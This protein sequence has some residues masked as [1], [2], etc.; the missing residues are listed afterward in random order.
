M[1]TTVERPECPQGHQGRVHLDGFYGRAAHFRRPRYKCIPDSGKP[2]R[3]TEPLP[4]RQPTDDHPH[5][6]DCTECGHGASRNGGPQTGRG[7]LFTAREVAGVL[8]DLGEG[9]SLRKA[10]QKARREAVR[11]RA[12][13]TGNRRASRH[14]QL[15]MNYLAAFGGRVADELLPSLWPVAVVLDANPFLLRTTY[16]DGAP[17]QGGPIGFNLMGAYGYSG[18]RG[19]G[20]L[21]RL[22]VR[23]ANDQVE[24]EVFLRSLP[25]TP[26]WVVSDGSAPVRNAVAAV[27]PDATFY[28][29]EGHL[30]R[31]GEE[32]LYKDGVFPGHPL[33]TLW[34]E[35]QW[36]FERW[37]R[38]L[39]ELHFSEASEMKSWIA[40]RGALIETQF[41]IRRSDRPRATG[42]LEDSLRNVKGAIGDR[43]FVFR[44]L[45]RLRLLLNLMALHEREDDDVRTYAQ[46]I[47][48]ALLTDGRPQFRALDDAGAASIRA[49]ALAA[50]ERLAEKREFARTASRKYEAKESK[51]RKE[52]KAKRIADEGRLQPAE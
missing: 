6:A 26:D 10:S 50:D 39:Y 18:A 44:N 30:L 5:G 20:A 16:S 35:A 36:T 29:C 48:R 38:F 25:G 4:R 41:E 19:T 13:H 8:H 43:H 2:H 27:W 7:F 47:R 9:E 3:F 31:S 32:R 23:G 52:R 28:H 17:R 42:A 45:A 12:D 37:E 51:R 49:Q 11:L 21:W 14:G 15:A 33:H 46:I 40:K 1:D 22:D 24:W 34:K